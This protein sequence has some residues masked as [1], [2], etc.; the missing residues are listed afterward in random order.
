[1]ARGDGRVFRRGQAWRI[2]YYAPDPANPGRMKEIR[3][4]AA[5]EAEAWKLLKLRRRELAVAKAGLRAFQ[6]P[7]QEN[8]LVAELLDGLEKQHEILGRRGLPQLKSHLKHI[9][10]AFGTDRALAVTTDRLR[11]YISQR[12]TAG[13]APASINRGIEALSAAFN[14]A[15][16][17]GTISVVPKFPSLPE[18]NAR[19]GFFDRNTFESLVNALTDD[20]LR[21]YLR[22]FFWTG[23]RPREIRSLTWPALDRETWTLR[24][25]ARDAKTGHGRVIPLQGALREII[26]QRLEARRLDCPYI[27]HRSGR[28]VGEFRKAWK[29]ACKAV[30]VVGLRPYDLRRTAV[31]NL[32][33]AGADPA[34]AMKISG[35][36]TRAVFDRYNIISEEDMRNA[37]TKTEAYV[38][39]LPT[40][41]QVVALRSVLDR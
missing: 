2:S 22:F 25:H 10:E 13:A 23:M 18:R 24:L 37:L 30:G 17:A 6:G 15:A 16:E 3:E 28:Q 29:T 19:Q 35:H 7:R 1:M 38:A 27:F 11:D 20:G 33:R 4:G 40:A 14:L 41:A 12:Q 34:V 31:R 26:E 8:V 5:T 21:D 36:K 32:V 9:R 39:A